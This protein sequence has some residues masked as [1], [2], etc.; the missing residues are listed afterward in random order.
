MKSLTV[1][2]TFLIPGRGIIVVGKLDS[3]EHEFKSGARVKIVRPDGTHLFGAVRGIHTSQPYLTE[4]RN[5]DLLL[6]VSVS[7]EDV[8]RGSVITVNTDER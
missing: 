5:I 2:D 4:Q 1:E 3:L 8:P 6:D 7:K